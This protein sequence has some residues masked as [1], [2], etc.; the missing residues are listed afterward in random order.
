MDTSPAATYPKLENGDVRHHSAERGGTYLGGKAMDEDMMAVWKEL[1]HVGQ[2][3][4][5]SPGDRGHVIFNAGKHLEKQHFSTDTLNLASL[6]NLA[7]S[8]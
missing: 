7:C 5:G 6:S 4:C 1:V 3:S 8:A 2:V